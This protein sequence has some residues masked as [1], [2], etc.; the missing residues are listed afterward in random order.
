MKISATKEFLF[1]AC[2]KLDNYEGACANLHGHTY[3]LQVTVSR[4]ID[5]PVGIVNAPAVDFMVMDF[6]ELKKIVN[7]EVI[8]THD[9]NYLNHLYVMTTAEF[10][11]VEIFK[12]LDKRLEAGL[13]LDQ[14]R[15]YETPTSFV[16]VNR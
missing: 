11:A 3:K 15:L 1:D 2:H 13:Q 5:F 8:S 9:H 10:M 12:R 14:V 7:E 6:N 16:T 4:D